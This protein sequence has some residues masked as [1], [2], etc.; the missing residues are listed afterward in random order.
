MIQNLFLRLRLNGAMS[1]NRFVYFLQR[2]PFLGKLFGDEWYKIGPIKTVISI[3]GSVFHLIYK[4]FTCSLYI[5]CIALLPCLFIQGR[6]FYSENL[7]VFICMLFISSGIIGSVRTSST[8]TFDLNKFYL[9]RIMRMPVANYAKS[10]LLLYYVTRFFIMGIC[11]VIGGL[12]CSVSPLKSVVLCTGILA[13]N[14][15][16]EILQITLYRKHAFLVEEHPWLFITVALSLLATALLLLL[17][18]FGKGLA[19]MVCSVPALLIYICIVVLCSLWLYRYPYYN[20]AC[21]VMAGKGKFIF[22]I[23]KT[24]GEALFGS[25]KMNDKEQSEEQIKRTTVT[26]KTGYDYLNAL[27]YKRHARILLKPAVYACATIVAIFMLLVITNLIFPTVGNVIANLLPNFLSKLVFVLYLLSTCCDRACKAMFYNCDI[28]LL[29]YGFYRK[30]KVILHNF[31]VRLYM[32]LGLNLPVSLLLG[33]CIFLY[34][35]LSG[36]FWP[37]GSAVLYMVG[38]LGLGIFF[39]VHH[40][41]CYYVFQ[42]YTSELG[43]KSPFFKIINGIV[44]FVSYLCLQIDTPPTFFIPLVIILTTLYCLVSLLLVYRFSPKTFRVK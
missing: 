26:G 37:T 12:L 21:Y 43:V 44:Y 6:L 35:K 5:A 39:A 18:G 17:N 23:D 20:D 42:P 30:P 9:L 33:V 19:A 13:I 11:I 1:G 4:L 25:V 40:L 24:K 7:H 27:F 8:L 29:R 16:G 36:V 32:L 10:N 14:L 31:A 28:A 34:T 15:A 2:I 3:V 22:E 41:F 38:I